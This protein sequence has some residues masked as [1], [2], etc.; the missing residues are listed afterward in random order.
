MQQDAAELSAEE[1]YVLAL[2]L[3]LLQASG[4]GCS[5][6]LDESTAL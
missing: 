1:E 5:W 2:Y 4:K 3:Y 6:R